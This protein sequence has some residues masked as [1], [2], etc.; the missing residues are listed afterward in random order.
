M[1]APSRWRT[2]CHLLNILLRFSTGWSADFFQGYTGQPD[3]TVSAEPFPSIP[4][5]ETEN[6]SEFSPMIRPLLTVRLKP[7]DLFPFRARPR[8]SA[9]RWVTLCLL[10]NTLI[11]HSFGSQRALKFTL[12][13][14]QR[15]TSGATE[16]KQ[17]LQSGTMTSMKCAA[18]C[19]ADCGMF[20]FSAEHS[21]CAVFTER[22]FDADVILT[23]DANWTVGYRKQY[24][25]VVTRGEWT[26]VFRGQS[27][28]GTKIYDTW[29]ATGVHHDSPIPTD[30]PGACLRMDHYTSCNR[31]FRSHIL[32]NW[33]N[34]KEVY[35]SW[36]KNN[37]EVAYIV[38]DGTGTDR[39]SWFF[40]SRILKSSWAPPIISD[41]WQLHKTSI[42]GICH[43]DL[44]RRFYLH[45][46][47]TTCATEWSYSYVLDMHP[48]LC[49]SRGRW[50]VNSVD[51]IPTFLYSPTN[52]RSA[53][54]I[55]RDYPLL[56]KADVLAI[57]VLAPGHKKGEANNT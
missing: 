22:Y 3:I 57:W 24:Y 2:L 1:M 28:I 4:Y 16:V 56:E 39:D 35:M 51:N 46:P 13:L 49:I 26:L 7:E 23:R 33:A 18:F 44:C 55:H 29:I 41:S 14:G 38:F 34:I 17:M 52:G 40:G 30:F 20:H 6:P 21:V 10:L 42:Y 9:I 36:I 54:G 48:D 5:L 31:H 19:G 15:I 50:D 11:R 32:D 12:S 8:T 25:S 43:P 47:H 45:G 53:A 27:G 37:A